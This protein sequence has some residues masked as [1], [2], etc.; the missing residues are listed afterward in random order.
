[1]TAIAEKIR[2]EALQLSEEERAQLAHSLILSLD[3]KGAGADNDWEALWE[4]ELNRRIAE[5]DAGESPGRPAED[6]MADIKA[7]Y[8]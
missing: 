8:S 3:D 2:A 7:K 5:I 6:V 4:V 1:M